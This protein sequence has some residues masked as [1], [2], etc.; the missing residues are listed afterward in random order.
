MPPHFARRYHTI[1]HEILDLESP[2]APVDASMYALLDG[3]IDEARARIHPAGGFANDAERELYATAVLLAIDDIL[4]KRNFVYPKPEQPVH[5]LCDGLTPRRLAPAAISELLDRDEN[6]RRRGRL[7]EDRPIYVIDCDLT[8]F[9]YLG[10]GEVLGLP[11]SM[12][13]VPRHNFVR[14][15]YAAGEYLNWETVYGLERSDLDYARRFFHSADEF[16][17][18]A[19][20]GVF[21]KRLDRSEVVG[22]AH[23]LRGETYEELGEYTLAIT[24]YRRAI[25]LYRLSPAAHGH[26]AWLL[27][28]CEERS[29]R[30]AW[31][32]VVFSEEAARL[33]PA[34][35]QLDALACA[36][37]ET[38]QFPA[39]KHAEAR[40]FALDPRPEYEQRATAFARA[41]TYFDYLKEK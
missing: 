24:D 39:A 3:I 21:F 23:L 14:W 25:S 17:D 16:T 12:V 40:A 31:E 36:Y 18:L 15:Y 32:G 33:W 5:L 7:R 34:A 10:V 6:Y 22:Y 27:L 13:E 19:R 8:C 38:S 35:A 37:A 2:V 30:D 20:R 26:L 41:R 4:I 11:L 9:V 29:L 1:A 28:T